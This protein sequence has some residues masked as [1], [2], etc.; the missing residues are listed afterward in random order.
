MYKRLDACL[1]CG[2]NK[3]F[4]VLD[5]DTQPLANSFRAANSDPLA[6]YELKLMGC[7]QCWHT[8]LSIAVDPSELFRHYLYV[9]GTSITLKEYFDWFASTYHLPEVEK[10][11]VL[12]IACNDGTQLESFKVLGWDTWG[13][14]PAENLHPTSV[15]KGHT[16]RCAFWNS[17]IAQTL[18]KF[19]LITAQNV[20]AHTADIDEFLT[21]CKKVMKRDGLLVIQTS[22]A[23][24]FDRNE[25]DTI[26]HEHISFFSTRSME[27]I[28]RRHK[29][30]LNKV[31]TT[32]IHGTS[33]VFELSKLYSDTRAVREQLDK[34]LHRYNRSFYDS[35]RNNALGCL[36]D[37]GK[38]VDR[39]RAQGFKIIGYGAAA[40]G[41]TVINAGRLKLDYIV[42][43]NPLK[44]NLLC[45]GS[46]IPVYSSQKLATEENNVV[47][48]PLAWNFFDEIK[49]KAKS[50]RSGFTDTYVRYFPSL[51]QDVD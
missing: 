12:D 31:Y 21:A 45:P 41:M 24:M 25:F 3:L 37:L 11:R 36:A 42:D 4:T 28:A 30:Q 39:Q 6:S 13:V 27:A 38:Y 14:D 23:T 7:D 40:K 17:N 16:V 35:Y 44:Q 46:D 22:Q 49:T 29:L 20:F 48:I 10:P 5:L 1:C 50:L 33:Y 51:T 32:D 2:N 19:D 9:S 34:E 26:Y 8:Q 15:S 18:P 43:D 47:I